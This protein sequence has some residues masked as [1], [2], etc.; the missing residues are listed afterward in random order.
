MNTQTKAP[1]FNVGAVVHGLHMCV[2][3]QLTQLIKLDKELGVPQKGIKAQLLE[4]VDKKI[5]EWYAFR[6]VLD[7]AYRSNGTLPEAYVACHNALVDVVN[8]MRNIQMYKI[9]LYCWAV[10]STASSK[11][12]ERLYQQNRAGCKLIKQLVQH[13]DWDKRYKK[14]YLDANLI[15]QAMVQKNQFSTARKS[16]SEYHLCAL[17]L[18]AASTVG[19]QLAGVVDYLIKSAD[20]LYPDK[21]DRE[22]ALI[23]LEG[24]GVYLENSLKLW[25]LMIEN[26][27]HIQPDVATKAL[28]DKVVRHLDQCLSTA[29]H[30]P[31][32]VLKQV[33]STNGDS[34]ESRKILEN[35]LSAL[36]P[37]NAAVPTD[38]IFHHAYRVNT[39][40]FLLRTDSVSPDNFIKQLTG[41]LNQISAKLQTS[42]STNP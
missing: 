33:C 16:R 10:S 30:V 28:K 40:L 34:P 3:S 18:A 2:T 41:L 9:P 14:N 4:E 7:K 15:I 38:G 20:Q 25:G 26:Y 36:Q 13:F 12:L 6:D 8:L 24:I 21:A 31:M 17:A 42:L 23:G 1:A 32:L 5:N 22:K 27:C 19:R 37:S 39:C 35:V 29:L 11:Q